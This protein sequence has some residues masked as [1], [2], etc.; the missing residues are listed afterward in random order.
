MST[1]SRWIVDPAHSSAEFRV[2]NFWGLMNVRGQFG[3]IDGWLEVDDDGS[4]RLEL[5]IDAASV[6]TGNSKR[7]EH[8]RGADFFDTE[9]HPDVRFVSSRVSENGDGDLH[10]Q[11]ELIAAGDRVVLDLRPT[12]RTGDDRI[13]IDASATVDQRELGMT[14]SPLGVTRT[15]TMLTVHAHLRP[16]R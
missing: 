11:G 7:D 4:R 2:P 12:V 14:W 3:S 15:P 10:V 1:T 8:L 13:E 9:R 5:I 16:E 6:N